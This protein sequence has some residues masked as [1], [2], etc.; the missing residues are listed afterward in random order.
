MHLIGRA[1]P[2]RIHGM[3]MAMV[4][5]LSHRLTPCLGRVPL[6]WLQ[7]EALRRSQGDAG[8]LKLSDPGPPPPAL[9]STRLAAQ[10]V[11]P[12]PCGATRGS[13]PPPP[14][15]AAHRCAGVHAPSCLSV[16]AQR[17]PACTLSVLPQI[18][19][20][21][22]PPPSSARTHICMRRRRRAGH[23]RTRFSAA[24]RSCRQLQCP[25]SPL[26]STST[27]TST[28]RL[29]HAACHAQA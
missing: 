8:A 19:A 15:C 5:P 7:L 14:P 26:R 27:S 9:L 1:L 12:D 11:P 3:P 18:A 21:H 29:P 24:P 16:N 22:A 2:A 6:L 17:C 28:A 23:E 4:G 25:P 20:S 13:L 10:Q